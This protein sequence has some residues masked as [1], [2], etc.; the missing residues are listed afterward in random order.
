MSNIGEKVRILIV[1]DELGAREALELILEDDY[2]L[3]SVATGLEALARIK[4]G[5][6]DLVLL[7]MNMPELDG[8]ET[9]KLIKAYDESI[10][11]IMISASDSAKKAT[12]AMKCGAYDYITK[13]YE[14]EEILTVVERALERRSLQKEVCFLRS[15][16]AL[17]FGNFRM[18]SHAP[19]MQTVFE[20][21]EKVAKTNTSVLITGESGTG[22]EL[23][24]RAIHGTSQRASKPFVP[25]NCAAIPS[26][27]ME[28]ELF[29]H[30]KG[31]FTGAS[32]RTT[33]KLEFANGGTLFL[34]EISSLKIE[35]QAKLLRVLQEM[36][37]NRVGSNSTIK[38]DV[39][40]VAATNCR[41]DE[42]VKE[43]RFRSDLYFRLNVIP[44]E[45]PP[46]RKRQG[47]IPLLA[48]HFLAKFNQLLKKNIK[49][50]TQQAITVL[51]R[52]PW[53]GN[54]RELENLFE[55]LVVLG[56][57]G[58]W[59]D[60]KDLPFELLLREEAYTQTLEGN[61]GD[62][63]LIHA[64]QAFERQ[65]ILRA[66]DRYRWNQSSTARS[67]GVHRNTLLQKMK[68]LSI[69]QGVENTETP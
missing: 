9:L 60:E 64:R 42:M 56:K 38:V 35:L 65:Y 61:P 39:R 48:N 4:E 32:C 44:I 22:K 41:L 13:P 54:I 24:A 12:A 69:N 59:I 6:F 55:R 34:D 8:I 67:L 52:Y 15:A 63:G 20:M 1:D 49:G 5:S 43:N 29:G 3:E 53:P 16:M 33:G 7:D 18:V 27:L 68:S 10:D 47:D 58:H 26:E 14:A 28:S 19:S 23:V 30:E 11:T 36:E 66:L 51:E 46:L 45:L 31:A 21:I 40:T 17:Q 37:F 25:I 2:E 50:I 57:D 62:I